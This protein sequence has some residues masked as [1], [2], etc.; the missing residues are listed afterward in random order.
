MPVMGH[1]GLTPQTSSSL[2]GFV[3]QGRTAE[4]AHQILKDAIALE[5][6]GCFAIVIESVPQKISEYITKQLTIP[7]IGIGAGA[8]TDGQVL[9][10][11]DALGLYGDFLPKFCKRYANLGPQVV[12]ALKR[13][14]EEVKENV[15]PTTEN[16]YKIKTEE[17]HKF[18]ERTEK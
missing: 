8:F 11:H 14:H 6:A 15:F 18:K 12:E 1:V 17:W 2:G 7:T 3:T 9:V 10:Y 4:H 5:K 13:Y 16:A